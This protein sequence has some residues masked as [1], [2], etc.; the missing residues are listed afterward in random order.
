MSPLKYSPGV[1]DNVEDLEKY[2]VGG[3]HPVHLDDTL[4]NGRYR[5]VH[6]LGFGGYATVWLGRDQRANKYVALKIIV[7][8]FSKDCSELKMLQHFKNTTSTHPGRQYIAT[9]LDSFW[10]DGPNGSHLCLVSPVAGPAISEYSRTQPHG[11]LR[12]DVAQKIAL[13]A[14]QGLA[15]LHSIDVG[16]GGKKWLYFAVVLEATANIVF[17]DFTPSNV[18]YQLTNLDSWTDEEV[19][20]RLGQPYKNAVHTLSGKD[21]EPSAP[22]YVVEPISDI[23]AQYV[24][25]SILIIDFGQSFFLDS[26]PSD[27]VGTPW[28]YRA[29]EAIFDLKASVHSDVWALACTIFEIRSGEALFEV[30]FSDR[31][32]ASLQIVQI[33][34]KLPERWWNAW[35]RRLTYFE[36]DGNLKQ[37]WKNDRPLA[38]LHPLIDQIKDIGSEDASEDDTNQTSAEHA[39]NHESDSGGLSASCERSDFKYGK[40]KD[41]ARGGGMPIRSV[42]QD[43]KVH[44]RRTYNR[45]GGLRARLV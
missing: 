10:I 35:D 20:E 13:Q 38:S 29:P 18:L 40:R 31:D 36:E 45:E 39:N 12:V 22:T 44:T 30:F 33:L 42:K 2:I 21:P 7:A 14:T 28:S 19:Y 8:E 34:G 24:T 32:D 15:F 16:H 9:L 17:T 43:A 4:D 3:F 41:L 25:E 23:Q 1:I 26:P 11:R 27:G 5:I 37:K 6:K